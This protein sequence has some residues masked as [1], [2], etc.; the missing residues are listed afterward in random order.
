MDTGHLLV[1][2]VQI[3][4]SLTLKC[5]KLRCHDFSAFCLLQADN[6]MH[7]ACL[8]KQASVD[9]VSHQSVFGPY[10]NAFN[11]MQV[12]AV[13]ANEKPYKYTIQ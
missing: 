5:Q 4:S 8:I 13:N 10:S 7:F 2:S 9:L 1:A 11:S 6:V 3:W 12:D